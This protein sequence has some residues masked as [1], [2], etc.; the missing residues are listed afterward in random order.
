LFCK[1]KNEIFPNGIHPAK[2]AQ[3]PH[4]SQFSSLLFR[5]Q[6]REI[7]SAAVSGDGV[8]SN[9]S[10]SPGSD[11]ATR[12]GVSARTANPTILPN[13]ELFGSTAFAVLTVATMVTGES[14]E[15]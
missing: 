13:K 5:G 2:R 1:K 8:S 10:E 3:Q 4:A 9:F 15:R 7:Q 11:A 6:Q 12:A 14:F